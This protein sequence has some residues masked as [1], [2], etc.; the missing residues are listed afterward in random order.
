ML[1]SADELGINNDHSGLLELNGM[2]PGDPLPRLTPDWIIE[3][4]NKSLTHRP[5]LWGHFGMAREVA[6]IAGQTLVDPVK[7]KLLPA[8]APVIK[9]TF[10]IKPSARA[11]RRWFLKT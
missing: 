5:D 11:L 2:Q 3:I 8:G 1:A 10:P 7:P 4:D 6:A 9:L